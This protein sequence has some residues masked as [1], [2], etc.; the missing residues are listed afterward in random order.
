[1]GSIPFRRTKSRLL[2]VGTCWLIVSSLA[3]AAEAAKGRTRAEKAFGV[4][5]N[6]PTTLFPKRGKTEVSERTVDTKNGETQQLTDAT[7]RVSGTKD[8]EVIIWVAQKYK[9]PKLGWSIPVDTQYITRTVDGYRAKGVWDPE[10]E[11]PGGGPWYGRTFRLTGGG[12]IMIEIYL[13]D[14]DDKR[15]AAEIASTIASVRRC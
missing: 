11:E 1:M 5:M 12:A 8:R 7:F 10:T 13:A 2:V 15:S 6:L 3:P 9:E 4:C 14:G